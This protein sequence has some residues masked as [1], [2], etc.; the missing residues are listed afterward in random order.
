MG[1]SPVKI[2]DNRPDLFIDLA[3][4]QGVLDERVF[5]LNFA[6]DYAVSHLTFGGYDVDQF[7]SEPITWHDNKSKYF[8][9]VGLDEVRMGD[10]PQA[11]V[12]S[13]MTFKHKKAVVDSGSSYI[14]MPF[15]A[16]WQFYDQIKTTTDTYCEV[17]YYNTL[18][19]IYDENEY[20]KLPELHFKVDG[21][22]YKVPRESLYVRI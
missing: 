1:L 13:G 16:F 14:L 19:C 5:S 12:L 11:K 4:E 9:A 3:Y 8:W 15:T 7:A 18:Y 10:G 22:D 6:G 17:D 21:K 2:G 20:H